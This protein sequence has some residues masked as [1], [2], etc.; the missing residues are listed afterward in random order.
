MIYNIYLNK[1]VKV[2][3]LSVY[4]LTGQIGAGKTE[5]AQIFRK[6]GFSCFCADEV[7]KELYKEKD[8]IL[9]INQIY[10]A[11]VINGKVNRELLREIIFTDIKIMEKIEN[12]IQP[13]VFIKFKKIEKLYKNKLIFIMPIIKNS[14]FFKNYEIIYINAN[15]EIRK[16][17]LQKRK[18]YNINMIKNIIKYQKKIDQCI[19]NSKNIIENDGTL[20]DLEKKIQKI[21][22]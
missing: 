1:I 2:F 12:Y 22:N 19:N 17:R 8:I 4:I 3:K 5:A 7:V 14:S 20:S 13:L 15:E 10:P 16:K 6:L 18:N 9:N 11:S 21:I